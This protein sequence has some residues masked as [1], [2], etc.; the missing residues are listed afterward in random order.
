MVVSEFVEEIDLWWK[1]E[2][3]DD[4]VWTS[5]EPFVQ[6]DVLSKAQGYIEQQVSDPG[7]KFSTLIPI[8]K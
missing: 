5:L 8:K 2:F 4:D 3:V 7:S 6:T 1:K